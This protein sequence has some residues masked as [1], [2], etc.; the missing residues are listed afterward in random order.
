[1]FKKISRSRFRQESLSGYENIHVPENICGKYLLKSPIEV[2]IKPK[3]TTVIPLGLACELNEEI[4]LITFNGKVL[5]INEKYNIEKDGHI[6]LEIKNETDMPMQIH[7]GETI[8]EA[9][10]LKVKYQE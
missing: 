7:V 5:I 3:R 4:A 2:L 9:Y 8:A 1:M 10:I 6:L